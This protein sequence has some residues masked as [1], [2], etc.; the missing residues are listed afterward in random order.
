MARSRKKDGIPM[1]T[2]TAKA[3]V[4]NLSDQDALL[5]GLLGFSAT[6]PFFSPCRILLSIK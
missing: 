2:L 1:Q 3:K 4:A 5:L 6:I